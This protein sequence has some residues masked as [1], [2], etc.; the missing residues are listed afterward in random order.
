MNFIFQT[1]FLAALLLLARALAVDLIRA[2]S[3]RLMRRRAKKFRLRTL[4]R[5]RILGR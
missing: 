2:V 4:T 1:I 5:L 3:L